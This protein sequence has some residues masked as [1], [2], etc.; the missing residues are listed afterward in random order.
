MSKSKAKNGLGNVLVAIQAAPDLSEEAGLNLLGGKGWNLAKMSKDGLPVPK[1]WVISTEMCAQYNQTPDAAREFMRQELLPKVVTGL[2]K[3]GKLPLLS[4][5]SGARKSMPG[6]MDTILNVGLTKEN[7]PQWE[8]ELGEKAARDCRRRLLQMFG[9]VVY[10]IDEKK[11]EEVLSTIKKKRRAEHDSDLSA[12]DLNEVL[13]GYER[14]FTQARK[15]MPETV[16]EQLLAASEAVFKSWDNER[17]KEYRRIHGY[18][19]DWGTA[20]TIQEMVFGN[21]NENSCTGVLFSRNPATGRNEPLGEFLPQA[22]GEDVVAGVRTPQPIYELKEWNPTVH[23]QLMK[24]AKQLEQKNRDAQDIEFTVQDGELYLLQTRSAKR[25]AMAAVKMAVEMAREGLISKEEALGRISLQQYETLCAP[26]IAPT[27][28]AK[29]DVSGLSASTGI[30]TGVAVF[31]SDAAVES[32]KGCILIAEETTPEDLP[33]IHAAKGILTATGGVTSHAAVVARGMDKVCVV[34]ASGIVF[35]KNKDG[36]IVS[37]KLGTKEI[38]EGDVLTVDGAGGRVWVGGG[39]PVIPGG[40]LPE[41]IELHDLLFE[42]F[43]VYRIVTDGR[44]LHMDFKM[45]YATYELDAK[46]REV[47]REEVL[48]SLPYLN[49]I[50]DLSTM[51]EHALPED[52]PI[53]ALGGS[54]ADD[55]AFE[56]KRK[57]VLDYTGDKSSIQVHLGKRETRYRDEF[58][59]AGFNVASSMSGAGGSGPALH[60]APAESKDDWEAKALAAYDG[61]VIATRKVSKQTLDRLK[62]R[63]NDGRSPSVALSAKQL[64]STALAPK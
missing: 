16:E 34:G 38:H 35:E 37:A 58:E 1:A 61:L 31:S 26:M 7:L 10:G 30:A 22:Q 18:S 52:A 46:P 17:A 53:L 2:Q 42:V 21:L 4:V 64:L 12:E 51:E 44:D 55:E 15:R 8:A 50:I 45:I 41:L 47:A 25:S 56:A 62:E 29:P 23:A 39:V 9:S 19:D 28:Q 59:R 54:T 40:D 33:G 36:E 24:L 13:A 11:F 60:I 43:P 3:N 32:E 49:G 57:A 6:M 63:K 5:R 48:E 27:F 20:V 14:V